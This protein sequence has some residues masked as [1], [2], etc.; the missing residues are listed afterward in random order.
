MFKEKRYILLTLPQYY[1]SKCILSHRTF[2]V[3]ASDSV[4]T[5]AYVL[6]LITKC[7]LH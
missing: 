7:I 4:S 6:S 3:K 5:N 2:K 1:I